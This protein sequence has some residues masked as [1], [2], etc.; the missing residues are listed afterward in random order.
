MSLTANC[1]L[2]AALFIAVTVGLGWLVGEASMSADA[3]PWYAALPKSALNP[4]GWVFAVVWPVLYALMAVAGAYLYQEKKWAAF[5]LFL[6]Q[7]VFNYAWSFVFF[8]YQSV[9]WGFFWIVLILVLVVKWVQSLYEINKPLAYMQLPYL[10]WLIFAAYL[11]GF[12][13]TQLNP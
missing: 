4:P 10:W 9:E 12:I 1:L 5:N 8:T 6:L 11:N 3:N 13:F 7:L 2:R